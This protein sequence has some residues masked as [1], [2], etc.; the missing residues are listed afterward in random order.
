[1]ALLEKLSGAR[2]RLFGD[3]RASGIPVHW[4]RPDPGSWLAAQLSRSA[5]APAASPW[6]ER[7]EELA[8]ETNAQG[9][10]PLWEGYA[11]HN[12]GGATRS[13][14]QVRTA[15][16]MGDLYTFLVR[17]RRPE[18]IVEFGTAFGVSGMYFLAGLEANRRGR[19]LTFEP[20]AVWAGFAERNLGQIGQRYQLT[21]GTFEEHI[22]RVLPP[23]LRIDM[24]FIDAIHTRE[25]VLPQLE[26]VLR[27]AA[28]DALVI[29]DDIDFSDDMRACWREVAQDGRFRASVALGERVG[30]VERA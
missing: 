10:Q 6:S 1:M 25:F 18:V 21:V 23:D 8:R 2:H 14:D 26:I 4:I 20:N 29:L 13:S 9:E 5:V 15:A 19:L 28:P 12:R 22:G 24:A 3:A 17:Q 7:I 27:H 11:G 30:I 16:A